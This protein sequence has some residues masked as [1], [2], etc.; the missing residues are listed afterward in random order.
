M[1]KVLFK[2]L[3]CEA[4]STKL[5]HYRFAFLK[6]KTPFIYKN[7]SNF[8]SCRSYYDLK[9]VNYV[10]YSVF[11][12]GELLC[13]HPEVMPGS[14]QSTPED[15]YQRARVAL[16]CAMVAQLLT[17]IS[18]LPRQLL[19]PISYHRNESTGL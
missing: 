5:Q 11:S 12:D 14:L 9:A 8:H 10:L 19:L 3:Q 13:G 2:F 1:A 7:S 6:H 17:L 18:G 4:K 16:R 15:Q